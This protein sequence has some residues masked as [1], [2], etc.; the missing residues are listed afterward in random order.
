M[1]KDFWEIANV[2]RGE[3]EY[4]DFKYGSGNYEWEMGNNALGYFMQSANFTACAYECNQFMGI[5]VRVNVVEPDTLR[6]WREV[7]L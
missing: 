2:L 4:Q 1:S 5:P 3:A 7:K 6:L